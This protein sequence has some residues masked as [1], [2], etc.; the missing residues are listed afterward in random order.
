MMSGSTDKSTDRYGKKKVRHKSDVIRSQQG[1]LLLL[2]AESSSLQFMVQCNKISS[3][4]KEEKNEKLVTELKDEIKSRDNSIALSHE[5]IHKLGAE[6]VSMMVDAVKVKYKLEDERQKVKKLKSEK[7]S[8]EKQLT[9]HIKNMEREK[10]EY[11]RLLKLTQVNG[12]D[13]VR[14]SSQNRESKTPMKSV[15]T[16]NK[17][18]KASRNGNLVSNEHEIFTCSVENCGSSF[19]LKKSF[20]RHMLRHRTQIICEECLESFSQLSDLK[21]HMSRHTG[22]KPYLCEVCLSAFAQKSN[23]KQHMKIHK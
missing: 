23:L 5:V 16:V 12:K 20:Q 18:A 6:K 13:I 4:K 9:S 21:R 11:E 3:I 22:E 1:Q 2:K 15:T 17:N 14:S 19:R 10:S 8:L 7:K